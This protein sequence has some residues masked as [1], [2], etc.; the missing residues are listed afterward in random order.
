MLLI[1]IFIPEYSI[2]ERIESLQQ[3]WHR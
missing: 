3:K 2:K 1:I